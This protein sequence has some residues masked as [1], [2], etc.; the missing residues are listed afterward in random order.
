[1]RSL[2]WR[3]IIVGV[4]CL[5]MFIPLTMVSDIV[6]SR[7]HYSEDTVRSVG[8]EW[9]GEQTISGPKVVIPVKARV[10]VT[11]LH[12]VIDKATGLIMRDKE[13]GKNLQKLVEVEQIENREPLY[14]YPDVFDVQISTE[15]Q[16]RHRGI[17]QVPVYQAKTNIATTFPFDRVE[18][19]LDEGEF[20]VWGEADLRLTVS[21]NR[22]LRGEARLMSDGNEVLMEPLGEGAGLVAR[23]S[24]GKA[25]NAFDL[26]LGLNGAAQLRV[27]PVGRISTVEMNSD[28]PDPSFGGAFLPDGSEISEDG[29]TA[30]WTI[31]H[32]ARSLPQISR[33]DYEPTAR[34]DTSFG[35]S[36][37]Q[38]ND[39]YQKAWRAARY[40]I[41]F[42]SLTFLT[43]LLIDMQSKRPVHPVQYLLI[44]LS[45]AVF[46]LLMLAYAEQIG[47]TAA[48]IGSAAALILL[49]L[50][51]GRFALK[52]GSRTWVLGGMLVLLYAV[53]YLILYSTDYAL[54]AGATLA[55][56]A[57]GATMYATRNEEWYGEDGPGQGLFGKRT[58]K[59]TEVP[60]GPEVPKD[61]DPAQT[62]EDPLATAAA[63]KSEG[64]WPTLSKED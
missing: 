43:V 15:T 21:S 12:N 10:T 41:L 3:F 19:T 57:I 5:V 17:F 63:T 33:V 46:T 59:S 7:K 9:G 38:P 25:Q 42:V 49:L 54:L 6:N 34:R 32:L 55:F 61:A 26:V 37:Y 23:L 18:A 44:G 53:L 56:I 2:G 11:E 50:M 22:A 4:L 48:Y 28:W 40:G 58:P 36:F 24:G 64:P 60:K 51:F 35:V 47:F 13:T 45:Q 14:I 30:K 20:A 62:A 31:P 39:F 16:M 1:M 27:A 29:F 8:Q 52:L